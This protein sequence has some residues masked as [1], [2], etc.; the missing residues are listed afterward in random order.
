MCLNVHVHMP[1]HLFYPVYP[2]ASH[3]DLMC[4]LG[5][6]LCL[7]V[8]THTFLWGQISFGVP[9]KCTGYLCGNREAYIKYSHDF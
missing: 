3:A 7:P 4:R 2:S 5:H 1:A 6:Y 9:I 8:R